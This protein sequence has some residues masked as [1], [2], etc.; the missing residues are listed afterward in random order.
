[1]PGPV[2]SLPIM[3]GLK[4]TMKR[5]LAEEGVEYFDGEADFPLTDPSLFAD[6]NHLSTKGRALYTERVA[7]WINGF[8]GR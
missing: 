5:A 2:A 3:H 4:A 7:A 8:I 1:L 6:S